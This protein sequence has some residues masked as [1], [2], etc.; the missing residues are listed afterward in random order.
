MKLKYL[1][2][3]PVI[4]GIVVLGLAFVEPAL[5]QDDLIDPV[6]FQ[7]FGEAAGYETTQDIRVI[8]ARIIRYV[9]TFLG[10]VLLGYL[11]YGGFLFMT[12]GGEA[13]KVT[14][15]KRT[16]I[17]AIVGMA[18]ILMSWAIATFI[19]ST[20]LGAVTGGGDGGDGDGGDGGFPTCPGCPVN[21]DDYFVTESFGCIDELN[22]M[23]VVV[24][25]LFNQNVDADTIDGNISIV[26]Q[27]GDEVTGT[28]NTGYHS[29]TFVPDTPCEAEPSEYC[30]DPS[31]TYN[32][33]LGAGLQSTS[34]DPIE[35]D[36]GEGCTA[37]FTTGT[38]IDLDDPVVS[39]EYPE[40]DQNIE[41]L[42]DHLMQAMATDSGDIGSLFFFVDGDEEDTGVEMDP[43]NDPGLYN[44][45]WTE[46]V[47]GSHTLYAQAY[48]CAGNNTRSSSISVDVQ[49]AHCFDGAQNEDETG[50]DCGGADCDACDGDACVDDGD[51]Q[52]GHCVDGQCVGYPEIYSFSPADGAPGTFMTISGE[53]FGTEE[54]VVTFLGEDVDGDGDEE[55]DDDDEIVSLASC[56]S[57]WE[58]DEV[59]IQVPDMGIAGPI[60]LEIAPDNEGVILS[61]RT[62]DDNG[63]T[64]SPDFE[65]NE[66]LRPGLC[67][68]FPESAYSE[69][70]VASAGKNFGDSEDTIYFIRGGIGYESSEYLS[71]SDTMLGYVVPPL[72]GGTYDIE[73]FVNGVGSNAV[74]FLSLTEADETTPTISY[75]DSG[76]NICSDRNSVWCSDDAGCA[77]SCLGTFPAS[78][79]NDMSLECAL[80]GDCNFG[81]CEDAGEIGPPGQYITIYGSNF[82]YN[83][84][85]VYFY[86]ANGD[87]YI[88]NTEFP[89]ACD[90]ATWS[91]ISIVVKV[92]DVSLIGEIHDVEVVRAD[93]VA[94]NQVDFTVID[95]EPTPGICA[96][97]PDSGPP[98]LEVTLYG[99]A[100][101]ATEGSVSFYNSL[102]ETTITLWE[103][104]GEEAACLVPDDAAT[105]PVE[106]ARADDGLLSNTLDFQVGD[107]NEEA[108]MCDA[109]IEVCC[110]D[111]SCQAECSVEV[112]NESSFMWLF[113]TGEIPVAPAVIEQCSE[114]PAMISPT[115]F[116]E[117]EGGSEACVNS[118]VS[119]SFL[120]PDDG[121]VWVDMTTVN[122]STVLVQECVHTGDIPCDQLADPLTGTLVTN[123]N[124][125]HFDFSEP[126][127]YVTSTWYQ[128]TLVSGVSGILGDDGTPMVSDY[129]W[130]FQTR[131]DAQDCEA[132]GVYV[133]PADWVLT[134][135]DEEK[136]FLASAIGDYPC[137][138]LIDY[139]YI[140][141][142]E[143]EYSGARNALE[144]IGFEYLD[145]VGASTAISETEPGELIDVIAQLIEYGVFSSSDLTVDFGEP[146]VVDRWPDCEEACI[147]SSVGAEFS[148]MMDATSFANNVAIYTCED[149]LCQLGLTS[150]GSL[151]THLEQEDYVAEFTPSGDLEP[152]TYYRVVVQGDDPDTIGEVEGVTSHSGVGL[153]GLNYDTSYSWIFKTKDD[154]Q[155]C[156]IDH[157][158]IDPE[159]AIM[160]YIGEQQQYTV[161]PYGAP[162]ECSAS[163]QRL[164]GYDY[165]WDWQ[166]YDVEGWDIAD[167]D[168]NML[169][170]TIDLP[171]GCSSECLN[172]GSFV[173]APICGNNVIEHWQQEI[174]LGGEDCDDGNLLN[175]DGCSSK[176]LNE[177]LM[178]LADGGDCGDNSRGPFEECD[179]GGLCSDNATVCD[180][181]SDCT[182]V[183]GGYCA[184]GTTFC[185]VAADCHQI[186]GL[187]GD[188]ITPCGV[189]D[190]CLEIEGGEICELY[191]S[192][193]SLN[194]EVCTPRDGD[195][196][197]AG[198]LNEGSRLAGTVCGND[199]ITHDH[200]NG[201]EECDDGN[202]SSG[203][204]CSSVCLNEGSDDADVI[205][206]VCGN[207]VVENGEDC[208]DFNLING[209]GCSTVCLNEGNEACEEVVGAG[210]CG[211]GTIDTGE[212]CDDW[213]TE[214][215]DGCGNTCLNEGSSYLYGSFCGD[216][217]LEDELGEECEVDPA[218]VGAYTDP[219]QIAVITEDAA[220]AAYDLES[221]LVTTEIVTDVEDDYGNDAT[222]S[223]IFGISCSCEAD[224][225]CGDYSV[226]GCGFAQCCFSR[227]SVQEFIPNAE[228][229]ACLN[230]YISVE[231]S[232][233][234]SR[235]S[236]EGNILLAYLGEDLDHDGG[237]DDP[238]DLITCPDG[239]EQYPGLETETSMIDQ[240]WY[241]RAWDWLKG[242]VFGLLGR[243]VVYAG[244]IEACILPGSLEI[245]DIEGENAA[246]TVVYSYMQ[247]LEANGV[248]QLI[249]AADSPLD[250]DNLEVTY[251]V[252]VGSTSL[253]TLAGVDG[254]KLGFADSV[255]SQFTTGG[256]ICSLDLVLVE[257]R[258]E[259]SPG[260]F[261]TSGE[262]HAIRSMAYTIN[263]G[264]TRPI[265]PIPQI[266]GWT[267]GWETSIPV[268]GDDPDVILQ[269]HEIS[270]QLI[271]VTTEAPAIDGQE[272]VIASATITED[273]VFDPSTVDH[274]VS[275]ETEEIV[276]LCENPWP[277]VGYF[278]F[279]D[280]NEGY[281]DFLGAYDQGLVDGEYGPSVRNMPGN[282]PYSNFSFYYC[283][284]YGDPDDLGDDL[285]AL[286]VQEVEDPPVSNIFRELLFIAQGEA[287]AD[288]IGVRLA[289]NEYYYSPYDWYKDQSFVGIPTVTELDGY[290]AVQDGNTI[291]ASAANQIGAIYPNIY[292]IAHDRGASDETIDIFNQILNNWSFNSN[293]DVND[294][295]V[296]KDVSLCYTDDSLED[297]YYDNEEV[298]TCDSD[299]DCWPLDTD[300]SCGGEKD[301]LRRDLQRLTD[302]RTIIDE[303]E[304]YGRI[305][306]HCSITTGESCYTDG[307]CPDGETCVDTVPELSVGTFLRSRAY[308]AWPSWQA[309]LANAL[310]SALPEDP[311]NQ[312]YDCPGEY[313]PDTCWDV[314]TSEFVC[315]AGSHT[316]GYR[317]V[318]GEEYELFAELEYNDA[319]WAYGIDLD[320]TDW[321]D[322][323]MY[324]AAVTDDGFNAAQMCSLTGTL[325]GASETCGDGVIGEN[326][327][328][329]IGDMT[330]VSCS[331]Y[332]CD[333]GEND[334]QACSLLDRLPCGEGV[335]CVISGDGIKNVAC[336]DQNGNCG[337]NAEEAC[338][339]W[340]TAFQSESECVAFT[341]GNGVIDGDEECDDGSFNGIYGYC[342]EDCTLYGAI[343]CG[344]GSL[345]GGE[346]CDCGYDQSLAEGGA[347]SQYNCGIDDDGDGAVDSYSTNGLYS[348][349]PNAGCAFDCS[350]PPAHCGDA[351]INGSETCDSEVETWS[352]T[353]CS[354]GPVGTKSRPCETDDDC[355]G[356]ECG[357]ETKALY[358]SCGTSQVCETGDNTGAPCDDDGDCDGGIC[359]AFEYTLT[360]TRSCDDVCEWDI[361]DRVNGYACLSG[362][363]C[364]NGSVDGNEECDDGDE[365]NNNECTN[366][367]LNNVCGDGSVY[368]G[369]ESCDSGV[370]NGQLC[371]APYGGTC[372]YCT[373]DCQYQTIS[374]GYC[375]DEEV[376]GNEFCDGIGTLP[377]Y[378][379]KADADPQQRERGIECDTGFDCDLEYGVL[380]YTCQQNIGYCDGGDSEDY[381]FNGTPCLTITRMGGEYA[382]PEYDCN[383]YGTCQTQQCY[384]N[385][386]AAC[387]FTME[388]ASIQIDPEGEVGPSDSLNLYSYLSGESP[389]KSS[390]VFPAC[391][392]GS[393][394]TADISFSGLTDP[395]IDLIFVTD[396]SGS[397]EEHIVDGACYDDGSSCD[398]NSDCSCMLD[399]NGDGLCDG[400]TPCVGQTRLE[401]TQEVLE[402]AIYELFDGFEDGKLKIG[403]VSYDGHCDQ[404]QGADERARLDYD[405]VDS[406]EVSLLVNEVYGYAH[407]GWTATADGINQ[408]RTSVLNNVGARSEAVKIIVLL[409]DGKPTVPLTNPV[410]GLGTSCHDNGAG[411]PNCV[412][413]Q[414][415]EAFSEALFYSEYTKD[416]GIQIFT[417]A[418]GTSDALEG[419][420]AWLSSE[421]C[422]GETYTD[423]T[424]CS[425]PTG[426][427]YAYSA[428]T[429]EEFYDMFD[430]II[431]AIRGVGVTYT[432]EIQGNP[433]TSGAVILDGLGVQLPFPLG[434]ECDNEEFTVP[435][436][437]EFN[438]SGA[439]GI[440]NI[441][442]EY[443]PYE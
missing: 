75:I 349:D 268:G 257:D 311:L 347:W 357:S 353:I 335:D 76:I 69:E 433:V 177:D 416:D 320:D 337:G 334:G 68:V 280:T 171:P 332:T 250:D 285:P 314:N 409:S 89:D 400:Y 154:L 346:V 327:V 113:S 313:D 328:C 100:F 269:D 414:N 281:Y 292:A 255:V 262:V 213:N 322:V 358:Q 27:G 12:A 238:D 9:L 170:A 381:I 54:G 284:D 260:L 33:T 389:D 78:C 277:A 408:G 225:D 181:N 23:N 121:G 254:A 112:V 388:T 424:D 441:E 278:P 439:L 217:V 230:S 330:T 36:L 228:T 28:Y 220:Q 290:Q 378:C 60:M 185:Q 124:Y 410:Q 42:I 144:F 401:V 435:F 10:V 163:G 283:R 45:T 143:P 303:V 299:L 96:I 135:V 247:A 55:G 316:Y 369:V 443:C 41:T 31:T 152:N 232:E 66:T 276:L 295:D 174:L 373:A 202:T 18:I 64:I 39:M 264:L 77:G 275:G 203:D 182:G 206:A 282:F 161:I 407:G 391:N 44:G 224:S 184:D 309:Q 302:F 365:D 102:E 273:L 252:G 360:R 376:N 131:A 345:A 72:A 133:D 101:G 87:E 91:T 120:Q 375:G 372:N 212:D 367:C 352:G 85:V 210:C 148:E 385:C 266:Y 227:P 374:G 17:N 193:C 351:I 147:N 70:P 140:W 442:F 234:M 310:G 150:L 51:C 25:V 105:G 208:D 192:T 384:S 29:I 142:W 242:Q 423:R 178:S 404:V 134:E 108:G 390:L 383:G 248:Y 194:P 38:E 279:E 65:I 189:D 32:I 145:S 219:I 30:F 4:I 329:E 126:E 52:G 426:T 323:T 364:G 362:N 1:K 438:A 343:F 436:R 79:T 81:T 425:S 421:E 204:G 395:Y 241:A 338:L 67:G 340:Q 73:V 317:S 149:A 116:T 8:I 312:M 59:I 2:L 14:K 155:P 419:K 162:D 50:V 11:I 402:S 336:C 406:S 106:L 130:Y 82:G 286:I 418:I 348:L 93:A 218:Y 40:D 88:G 411:D 267:W 159:E 246:T 165:D 199:V 37:S 298:V 341:C 231:F 157:T 382:T 361:W 19:I 223:G 57:A 403:L 156:G 168:P 34:D 99:E 132:E 21:Y 129:V 251:N 386:T 339:D 326:E 263:G 294:Q 107:C 214:N 104:D 432:G 119:A 318:G 172:A 187:C 428:G 396:L 413:C 98:G 371:D 175:G 415:G 363:Y 304:D 118:R 151:N 13:D 239:Y 249:V 47:I 237:V 288:A 397:M 394:L 200:N 296:I 180:D 188:G 300:A 61:D 235:A 301:K 368:I 331:L 179:N 176:C 307:N 261:T 440:E 94:S 141:D 229:Y 201:G 160:S 117:W 63:V 49:P 86:D 265:A 308:S 139:G 350:G 379:F 196:C 169:N 216:G 22:N 370:D 125:F 233:L 221:S 128:V 5:A 315:Y 35:C 146:V 205:Y 138:I 215:N 405:L 92:P 291:Y 306:R 48:D 393:G 222:S 186:G 258:D 354:G 167:F 245:Q 84:G 80:E 109:E 136:D 103:N 287:Y 422:D 123:D 437:V 62:D 366:E 58:D 392:V 24:T 166:L 83:E 399:W 110:A 43:E 153:V 259:D 293:S 356:Y 95:G 412:L 164:Q 191:D 46:P 297:I 274:V 195:G 431:D 74:S 190:D 3:I 111:G 6:E 211:N 240:S 359:S 244:D 7:E 158:E 137:N 253:V 114:D 427:P 53:N 20:L 420:M 430:A 377:S 434:F 342:G 209:D 429:S 236:L 56:D 387:P 344:D 16:I 243:Q 207:G 333:G 15:A 305:T 321:A 122:D 127:R 183:S 325:I 226:Y 271:S 270:A 115:P 289:T 256:D 324:G 173:G 197:S 71:W 398:E 319:P 417:A 198:C 272:Y 97:S 26:E 90:G 380:T 355:D